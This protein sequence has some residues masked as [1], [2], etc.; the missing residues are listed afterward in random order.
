MHHRPRTT[1]L[2]SPRYTQIPNLLQNLLNPII[3]ITPRILIPRLRIKILLH[4]GH[5][6]IRLRT[7]AQLNLNQSLETGIQ[8]RHAQVDQLGKLGE[9]LLVEL[10]VGLL[11]HFGLA[12]GPGQLRRVLV[13]LFDELLDLGAHGVVVEELVVALF[14]AFV[15]VGEVGAEAGDWVEDGGPVVVLVRIGFG[16]GVVGEV[17]PIWPV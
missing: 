9:Q 3:Q 10:L 4:L 13:G 5:P 8:V 16:V 12:L 2:N 1:T 17:L 14:D 11:G 15:D 7:K 6:R